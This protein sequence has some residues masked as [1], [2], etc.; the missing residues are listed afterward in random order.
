V[1]PGVG[2]PDRGDHYD[3]CRGDHYDVYHGGQDYDRVIDA[4]VEFL[5]RVSERRQA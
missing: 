1:N 2:I 4:E 5:R 3:V